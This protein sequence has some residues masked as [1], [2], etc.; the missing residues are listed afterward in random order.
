MGC[1]LHRACGRG[2][3]ASTD[4]GGDRQLNPALHTIVLARL[5]DDPVSRAYATRRRSQGK[6]ATVV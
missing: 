5:R 6:C 4:R 3:Q 2:H 1:T